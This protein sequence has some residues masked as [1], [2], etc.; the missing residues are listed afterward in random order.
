VT[1]VPRD[2][3]DV[4]VRDAAGAREAYDALAAGF[5]A[6]TLLLVDDPHPDLAFAALRAGAAAVLARS[7]DGTELLAA[8]DAVRAGLLVLDPAAR[9]A[10]LPVA[11]APPSTGAAALTER[12]RQVL[13]MLAGGLSNR[14]IAERLSI[15]ENTVKAHVATIFGKLGA[16]TRTEAVAIAVRRGLVML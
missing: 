2:A 11:S 10:L 16:S 14:R 13:A 9:E 5:T 1:I 8:I 6:P 3:A 12:E 15:A 7:A 4:V